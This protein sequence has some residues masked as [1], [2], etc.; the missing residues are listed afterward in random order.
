MS[1]IPGTESDFG[2]GVCFGVYVFRARG[3]LLNF[4]TQESES[5][6]I[7]CILHTYKIKF[8][9]EMVLFITAYS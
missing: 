9:K 5:Q 3:V 7:D 2:P 8:T 4:L 1:Y 6:K